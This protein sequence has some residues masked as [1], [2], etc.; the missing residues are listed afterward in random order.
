MGNI[1]RDEIHTKAK[2]VYESLCDMIK[3][4]MI[5]VTNADYRVISVI[6]DSNVVSRKSFM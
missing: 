3:Q 4:V 1:Q 2:V 5:N 6:S